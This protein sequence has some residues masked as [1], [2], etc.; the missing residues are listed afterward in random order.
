VSGLTS[1]STFLFLAMFSLLTGAY[2]SYLASPQLN[3]VLVGASGTGKTTTLERLKVTHFDLKSTT[4]RGRSV[5]ITTTQS[6]PID[7]T[8]LG[9]PAGESDTAGVTTT[10]QQPHSPTPA[11]QGELVEV[12][13]SPRMMRP[14]HSPKCVSS[15][16]SADV[17]VIS[18]SNRRRMWVCPAPKKYAHANE[19]PDDDDDDVNDSGTR[20]LVPS[21]SQVDRR[22][23]TQGSMESVELNIATPTRAAAT[24]NT[25][26]NCGNGKP[27]SNSWN[28]A[29]SYDAVKAK[30]KMLPLHRI[31]PTI[32]TNVGKVEI[33]GAKCSFYDVGGRLRDLWERYYAD[34]DAVIFVWKVPVFDDHGE[35]GSDSGSENESAITAPEQQELLQQVRAAI[36]DDVPFLVMGHVFD[37]ATTIV[38]TS[39]RPGKLYSTTSCLPHYHNPC[40]AMFFVNAQSGQG[41]TA[42]MEWLIPLAKRQKKLRDKTALSESSKADDVALDKK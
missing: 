14:V 2:N 25:D 38:Q 32:G 21:T 23:S 30:H 19:D 42:S 33:G 35:D 34:A 10:Q 17:T 28:D 18:T 13:V 9:F 24:T 5:M 4:T 11:A 40:Q 31:R 39:C 3:I 12:V 16:E 8:V 22:S 37:N 20:P 15:S 36:S 6:T 29:S 41:L 27:A 26:P 1:L 7:A